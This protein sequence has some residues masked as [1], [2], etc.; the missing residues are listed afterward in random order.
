MKSRRMKASEAVGVVRTRILMR[1]RVF[2]FIQKPFE[3]CAIARGR[4][5]AASG[6]ASVTTMNGQGE[7]WGD[8]DRTQNIS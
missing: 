3:A 2:A 1:V 5:F 4:N 8:E 6:C 7:V